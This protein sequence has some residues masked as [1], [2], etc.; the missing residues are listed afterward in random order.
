MRAV[1]LNPLVNATYVAVRAGT[2]ARRLP[3]VRD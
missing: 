3:S 1:L 2:V